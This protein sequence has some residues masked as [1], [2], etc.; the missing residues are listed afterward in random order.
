MDNVGYVGLS[1]NA[2][3]MRQLD[4]VANNI[5]N[6]STNG[7]RR[8]GNVFA[9]H[10]KALDGR[11]PSLSVSTLSRRFVDLSPGDVTTTSNPLDFAIE[12]DGFFLVE[13]QN[14]QRLTRDGAFSRN[15]QN[16]LVTSGDMR[17]LDDTGGAIVIPAQAKSIEAA[18]DGL[19]FADGEPIGRLGVVTADPAGLVREGG[20]LFRAEN[21]FDPAEAVRVRQFAV[22][23]SNVNAVAELAR[24]IEVQ[25]TYEISQKFSKDDD[26]RINRTIRVLGHQS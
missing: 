19:I 20:N 4:S 15:A 5:A 9:E 16:E 3:L 2:G 21:G 7:Y 26:E 17:V 6:V 13:T 24:L 23:G 22:E 12:G 14:G 18:N 8:E 25:R 1:R 11:D 10:I